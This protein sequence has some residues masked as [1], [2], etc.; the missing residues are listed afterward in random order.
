MSEAIGHIEYANPSKLPRGMSVLATRLLNL[1]MHDELKQSGYTPVTIT[2]KVED[3]TVSHVHTLPP[4]SAV[5]AATLG[6]NVRGAWQAELAKITEATGKGKEYFDA[7]YPT[8]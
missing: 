1:A 8:P 2:E 3:G 7:F 4:V 6:D 5:K